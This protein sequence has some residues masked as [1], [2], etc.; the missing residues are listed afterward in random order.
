MEL[1]NG[2]PVFDGPDGSQVHRQFKKKI[3]EIYEKV[4]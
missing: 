1:C 3:D 4:F 2:G